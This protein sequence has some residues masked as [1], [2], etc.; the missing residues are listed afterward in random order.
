M[1]TVESMVQAVIFA[2]GKVM[3]TITAKGVEAVI[4]EFI[5]KYQEAVEA[6]TTKSFENTL[7]ESYVEV[8]KHLK[9]LELYDIAIKF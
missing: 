6:D 1:Q 8:K 5:T 7:S 2:K 9:V 4:G 3:G